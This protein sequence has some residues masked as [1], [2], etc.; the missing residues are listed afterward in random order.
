[1]WSR[2][3]AHGAC[4]VGVLLL[5]T[6]VCGCADKEPSQ[7]RDSSSSRVTAI[8]AAGCT[9]YAL[10]EGVKSHFVCKMGSPGHATVASLV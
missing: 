2:W 4:T 10:T 3:K 1:M 5:L 8:A 6:Q 7:T 9:A